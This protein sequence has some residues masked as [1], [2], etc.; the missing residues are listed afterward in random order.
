MKV[1]QEKLPASQIGLDIEISP[2]MSKNAYEQVIR[3]YAR[4]V[5]IPG[6]RKGKVPRHILVQRLGVGRIKAAALD[7]LMQQ[8]LPKA[9]EQENIPAIGSFELR[10]DVE[11]LVAQYEPGQLL[12]IKAAVDIA[13]EVQLGEYKGLNVQAEEVKFDPARVD[14]VLEQE[15]TKL[16]TLVPVENRPAQTGDVAFV[17]FKGVFATEKNEEG[18][19]QEIPG[20][21]AENFQV[22]LIEGQFIPGFTEGMIGMNPGETKELQVTF[23]DDYGNEELAGQAAVF[24]ITLNELKVKELPELDD[25][26]AEEVSEFETLAE[27]RESLEKRFQEEADEQT[28]ANKNKALIEAIVANLQVEL[29]ETMIREEVD[30]VLTQQAMQLSQMGVDIKRLFTQEMIPQ[31]RERSRPQAIEQLKQSLALKE[32]AQQES[33]TISE[34]DIQAEEAKTMTQLQG[35]EVDPDRLREVVSENLLKKKTYSWLVENS[36]VELVPQGSLSPSEE[37][38]ESEESQEA[39]TSEEVASEVEVEV[40]TSETSE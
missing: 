4:S 40:L 39:E 15:Q 33:I 23:P 20:G 14:E 27:L 9:V 2:E 16:A 13:P 17:D 35:Q 3:Q 1:T 25:D 28:T 6:F 31:M 10:G 11:E 18:E 24:T 29:P 8:C 12:T 5:N 7:D 21:S 19:P 38:E 37:S 34:E 22:E 26:F 30:Q 36:T 32:I